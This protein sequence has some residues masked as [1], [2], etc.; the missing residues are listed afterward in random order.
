MALGLK[1][2]ENRT[3]QPPEELWGERFALH[4]G[5]VRDKPEAWPGLRGLREGWEEDELCQ[6]QGLVIAT[7]RLIDVVK[8]STSPWA[9][10]GH[11]QWLLDDPRLIDPIPA[12]GQMKLWDLEID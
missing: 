9:Q 5:L 11:W 7:V 10:R 6:V 12:K 2:I 3:W 8:D 4:A 1:D